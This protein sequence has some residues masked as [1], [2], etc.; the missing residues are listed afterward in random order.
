MS[1]CIQRSNNNNNKNRTKFQSQIAR[2]NGWHDARAHLELLGIAL[3][4]FQLIDVFILHPICTIQGRGKSRPSCLRSSTKEALAEKR[5][6][7]VSGMEVQLDVVSLS[8]PG[9]ETEL[10]AKKHVLEAPF[11]SHTKEKKAKAND[12]RTKPY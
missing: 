8:L 12:K 11:P 2:R 1:I 6:N 9:G 4:H 3:Q 5:A 10:C 7:R